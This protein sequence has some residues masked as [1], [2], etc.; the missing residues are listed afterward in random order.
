MQVRGYNVGE[1][2]ACRSFV[3]TAAELR[4]PVAGKHVYAFYE[5]GSDLGS[6]KHVKG[7]PTEYYRRAGSGASLGAGVKLGA[8]RM[9]WATDQNAGTGN[10]FVRFGERF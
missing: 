9:E 8:V 4:V 2:A 10:L 3:E 7:N 1:L 5:F 6:S